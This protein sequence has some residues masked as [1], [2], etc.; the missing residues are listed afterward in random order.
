MSLDTVIAAATKLP[1]RRAIPLRQARAMMAAIEQSRLAA[2]LS[3]EALARLAGIS[4][5]SYQR[6]SAGARVPGGS[7]LRRLARA[8]ATREEQRPREEAL[9]QALAARH[10]EAMAGA[11][12]AR[13]ARNLAIYLAHVELG[14]PQKALARLYGVSG[15]RINMVVQRIEAKR[16]DGCALDLQLMALADLLDRDASA[17]VQRGAA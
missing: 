4:A 14:L 16:D 15:N 5:R 8:L 12:D 2:G 10:L 1:D 7:E 6:Y 13:G 3:A 9:L 11:V 17:F